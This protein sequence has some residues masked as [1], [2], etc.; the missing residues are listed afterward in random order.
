MKKFAKFFMKVWCNF[1]TSKLKKQLKNLDK[2]RT[3]K[4]VILLDSK[5]YFITPM[6]SS[7]YSY[8]CYKMSLKKVNFNNGLCLI[9]SRLFFQR[10]FSVLHCEI[11]S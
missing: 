7:L 1:N 8:K 4:F 9:L 3:E 11:Y 10:L 2:A 6:F 5:K